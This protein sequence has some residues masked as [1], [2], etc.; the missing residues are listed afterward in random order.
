M[1]KTK[2]EVKRRG[3]EIGEENECIKTVERKKEKEQ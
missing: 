1:E 2:L 3:R